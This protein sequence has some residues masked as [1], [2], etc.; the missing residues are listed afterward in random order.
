MASAATAFLTAMGIVGFW[1]SVRVLVFTSVLV[2]AAFLAL[3]VRRTGQQVR[4][5]RTALDR[6]VRGIREITGEHRVE[7]LGRTEEIAERLSAV[8]S[9]LRGEDDPGEGP[10]GGDPRVL[11]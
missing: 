3:L 7:L 11:T 9:A 1:D 10:A 8:E 6:N 4:Q 2:V 5:L